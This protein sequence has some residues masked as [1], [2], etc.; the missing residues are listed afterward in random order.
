MFAAMATIRNTESTML[1]SRGCY[2]SNILSIA[3]NLHHNYSFGDISLNDYIWG[4]CG[5]V[6]LECWL[7]QQPHVEHWGSDSPK[8]CNP[9][10][11]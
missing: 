3:L 4:S 2:C 7:N 10:S 9:S 1:E 8:I 6:I 11:F 5:S